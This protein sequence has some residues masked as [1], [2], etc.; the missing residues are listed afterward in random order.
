MVYSIYFATMTIQCT[1]LRKIIQCGVVCKMLKKQLVL[2]WSKN[3]GPLGW[4]LI[5]VSEDYNYLK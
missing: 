5:A 4:A 1:I 2:K 3:T